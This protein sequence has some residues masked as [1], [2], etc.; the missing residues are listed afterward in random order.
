MRKEAGP[1]F[2]L[3]ILLQIVW[4]YSY[5]RENGIQLIPYAEFLRD[6]SLYSKDLFV[7]YAHQHLPNER[8]FFVFLIAP[9]G[10]L[11]E[12]GVFIEYVICSF[13]LLYGLLTLA[14]HF[15]HDR[16]LAWT[17][18]ILLSFPLYYH[19]LG[20][21]ELYGMEYTSTLLSDT[22]S[23][24]A[25][26]YFLRNKPQASILLLIPAT[27]A[28]PL[29]GLQVFMLI[30]GTIVWRALRQKEG[31]TAIRSLIRPIVLY[32]FTAGS[33]IIYLNGRFHD[34]DTDPATL[35]QI[36]FVFR[37]AHHYLPTHYPTID[38]ILLAPFYL[39]APFLF[40]KKDKQTTLFLSLIIIGCALYSFGVLFLHSPGIAEAQ[41]FKTTSFL[42]YFAIIGVL[43]LIRTRFN[44]EK[45]PR[46]YAFILPA[47]II[48][49]LAW[50]LVLFPGISYMRN[51]TAREYPF[52]KK[53][54]P[55]MDIAMQAA[56]YVPQDALC[57]Q[58]C[59]MDA[60]KHYSRRSSF[61]DYK[62][63]THSGNFLVEWSR[64]FNLLYGVD[65]EHSKVV[66]FDAVQLADEHYKKLTVD[67]ILQLHKKEGVT[68][69]VMFR[70]NVLPFKV[71]AANDKYI[72]YAI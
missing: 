35:F 26:I 28:H 48:V 47:T 45:N 32:I 1:I 22:L 34:A 20:L 36:F 24:W 68:H 70:E 54:T 53:V 55:E 9:L 14:K 52:Y 4:G 16:K 66:S 10:N 72:L 71:L 31:I 67:Q 57:I 17:A 6:H 46:V 40:R 69:V 39:A 42:E 50:V 60:F 62:A 63:L 12:W 58:P 3:F 64:R 18:L 49:S 8:T 65:P 27:L 38:W 44:E 15:L 43:M 13:F 41:W 21:N 11:M 61:V 23:I 33:F 30:L 37:N 59:S 29:A 51:S 56:Q 7:Q 2:L 5:G 25:I 19:T